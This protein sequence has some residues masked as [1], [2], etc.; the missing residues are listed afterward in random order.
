MDSDKLLLTLCVLNIIINIIIMVVVTIEY[1]ALCSTR[2]IRDIDLF[3]CIYI[4]FK[5]CREAIYLA[6]PTR[7]GRRVYIFWL[8]RLGPAKG[9]TESRNQEESL[10]EPERKQEPEAMSQKLYPETN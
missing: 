2:F 9:A 5:K 4:C 10:K 8:G 7:P 3:V 1:A 6:P